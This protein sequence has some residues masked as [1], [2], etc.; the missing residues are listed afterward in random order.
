[1]ETGFAFLVL[2]F[3]PYCNSVV[4]KAVN[5]DEFFEIHSLVSGSKMLVAAGQVL[6]ILSIGGIFISVL[7]PLALTMPRVDVSEHSTER[8]D[9]FDS[10]A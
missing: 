3:R 7:S 4:D 1:M 9:S 5:C 2:P 10:N 8:F 6:H